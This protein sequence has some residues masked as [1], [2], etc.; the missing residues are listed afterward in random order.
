MGPLIRP[1]PDTATPFQQFK[2]RVTS[3]VLPRLE[4]GESMYCLTDEITSD[5]VQSYNFYI[6]R[7]IFS[8]N[9]LKQSGL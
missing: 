9:G 8:F 2:A 7:D 1:D 4:I 6:Q 3:Q 5:E